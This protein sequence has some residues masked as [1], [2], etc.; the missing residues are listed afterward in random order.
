MKILRLMAVS[1]MCS[2]A[3][4]GACTSSNSPTQN[5]IQTNSNYDSQYRD[6]TRSAPPEAEDAETA[7][8]Q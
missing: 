1:V 5:N 7:K 2:A 6:Q 8:D 4:F 3:V